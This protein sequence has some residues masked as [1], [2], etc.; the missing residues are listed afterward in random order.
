MSKLDILKAAIFTPGAKGRWGLP[1]TLWGDPGIGKTYKVR[2][3]GAQYSLFY[4]ELSPGSRGEGA[5]G[6]IPFPDGKSISYPPPD[7]AIAANEAKHALV[8][9]DE[10][11]TAP[12]AVQPALLGL[13]QFGMIGSYQL[14][15]HVRTLA[16]AN[17]PELAAAG[18]D[19][20][21]PFANRQGHLNWERPAIEEWSEYMS[22]SV[23]ENIASISA[24]SEESRVLSV[25]N[26]SF[27][28]AIGEYGGFLHRM[29]QFLHKM[30]SR[31]DPAISRAWPSPRTN[32]LA[33]RALASGYVH[34]LSDCD[35]DEFV[36]SFVGEA[37]TIEFAHW[38]R[39]ADLPL[40]QDLLSEKVEYKHSAKRLDRTV[41][42]LSAC[43][44]YLGDKTLKNR[45]RYAEVLWSVM[46]DI[47]EAKAQ[48]L[49]VPAARF[50]CRSSSNL[51]GPKSTKEGVA[52][53]KSL[54]GL[55]KLSGELY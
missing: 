18:Y 36:G 34:G 28:R 43:T 37:C 38:R 32:E 16:T 29:P 42:I 15:P 26:S 5:F 52:V 27:S 50:L 10:A 24:E 3:L 4:V 9:I 39:E 2:E 1:L 12:P 51:P 49:V 31:E 19:Y 33:C 21:P 11:T 23:C 13:V 44:A 54:G 14:G 30:P 40:P 35:A 47:C 55:L 45:N 17:P 25:W 7:W 6:V 46:N 20:P 41:A 48:D 8:L 53:L 22:S